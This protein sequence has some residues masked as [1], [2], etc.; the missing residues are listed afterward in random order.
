MDLKMRISKEQTTDGKT[1]C[2]RISVVVDWAARARAVNCP[3][4]G[5]MK[6]ERR[7]GMGSF[8]GASLASGHTAPAT[9]IKKLKK[10]DARRVTRSRGTEA[11]AETK[12]PNVKGGRVLIAPM[13]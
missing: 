10:E 9:D 8:P 1:V 12:T 4:F 7:R 6:P 5:S 2:G 13:A 3:P 11:G